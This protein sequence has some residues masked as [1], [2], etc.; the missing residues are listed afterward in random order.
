MEQLFTARREEQGKSR[1]GETEMGRN[2]RERRNGHYGYNL[3]DLHPTLKRRTQST[4][5]VLNPSKDLVNQAPICGTHQDLAFGVLGQYATRVLSLHWRASSPE[6]GGRPPVA[7]KQRRISTNSDLGVT[8]AVC[9]DLECRTLRVKAATE[10]SWIPGRA[11]LAG[12]D[13]HAVVLWRGQ[14]SQQ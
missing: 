5:P 3:C 1:I 14:G 6:G 7:H 2:G 9:F 4:K 10:C 8:N 12:N 13:R 11:V